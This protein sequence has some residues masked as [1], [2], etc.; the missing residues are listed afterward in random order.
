MKHDVSS[1][2]WP[3]RVEDAMLWWLVVALFVTQ[4]EVSKIKRAL[5]ALL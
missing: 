3:L 1:A 4:R 5:P 2:G